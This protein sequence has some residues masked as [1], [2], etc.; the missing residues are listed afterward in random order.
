MNELRATIF[1][2]SLLLAVAVVKIIHM[3]KELSNHLKEHKTTEGDL[4]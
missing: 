3:D 1:A 4:P 2:I